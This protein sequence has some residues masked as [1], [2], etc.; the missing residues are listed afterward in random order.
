MIRPEVR[1]DTT[2]LEYFNKLMLDRIKESSVPR[3]P[4]LNA[5]IQF[6]ITGSDAGKWTL[7]LEDGYARGVVQGNH[8]HPDCILTLSGET[9]MAIVRKEIT[10][11]Q[12]LFQKKLAIEG[13]VMLGIKMT[14]LVNY[15]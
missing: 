5:R 15:L 13:N 11:Q 3:I 2:H 8:T 12:A 1:K 14:V 6:N 10:P 7:I 9:F 4:G